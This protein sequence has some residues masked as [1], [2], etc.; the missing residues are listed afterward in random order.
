MLQLCGGDANEATEKLLES[1]RAAPDWGWGPGAPGAPRRGARARDHPRR[2]PGRRPPPPLG[3]CCRLDAPDKRPG[4]RGRHGGPTR[5]CRPPPPAADPFERVKTKQEK[6]KEVRAGESRHLA[7]RWAR[8][9]GA[10]LAPAR[11]PRPRPRPA[12]PA[13]RGGAPKG[14]GGCPQSR[15]AAVHPGGRWRPGRQGARD[16]RRQRCARRGG[17]GGRRGRGVRVAGRPLGRLHV[18][19]PPHGAPV[20]ARAGRMHTRGHAASRSH[21]AQR[22]ARGRSPSTAAHP[23]PHRRSPQPRSPPRPTPQARGGRP[24]AAAAA[25]ARRPPPTARQLPTR[26]E[27]RPRGRCGQGAGGPPCARAAAG[28]GVSQRER[29]AGAPFA[30]RAALRRSGSPLRHVFTCRPPLPPKQARPVGLCRP[31]GC[32]RRLG[33]CG[34]GC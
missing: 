29:Y 15:G 27:Q 14:G 13:G 20:P 1:E 31:R 26:R 25:V 5:A 12:P 24:A 8:A 17:G 21:A 19:M 33:H 22:A 34:S 30:V 4:G 23:V 2:P 10:S 6:R 7:G 18:C 3:A 11:P 16:G 9:G 28:V 32:G